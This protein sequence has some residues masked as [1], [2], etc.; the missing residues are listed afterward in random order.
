MIFPFIVRFPLIVSPVLRTKFVV[1]SAEGMAEFVGELVG[2]LTPV[3]ITGVQTD[4][5]FFQGIPLIVNDWPLVSAQALGL[6]QL[7]ASSGLDG[8]VCSAVEAPIAWMLIG[9]TRVWPI[10]KRGF[11]LAYGF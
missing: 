7:T 3:K 1:E 8:V 9:S 5:N 2:I 10:V 6:A 4:N 11:R